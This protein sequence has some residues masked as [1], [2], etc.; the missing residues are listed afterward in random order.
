MGI[1]A[2]KMLQDEIVYLIQNDPDIGEILI[3]ENGEHI[4][5]V[6]KLNEMDISYKLIPSVDIL[7]NRIRKGPE[8][9]NELP[10]PACNEL[11]DQNSADADPETISLVVW[12]LDLGLHEVPKKLKL[13][14]YHDL[15]IMMPKVDGVFLFYGL[16][17]NVLLTVEDD[18][19]DENCPVLILR[20]SDGI[21]IDDC[22]G[23]AIG[24][25]QKYAQLLKSFKGVGTF[26]LTPMYAQYAATDFFGYGQAV[27]GFSNEKMYEMNK[28]MF[29]ASGYKQTALLD[30]GLSYTKNVEENAQK[31]ADKYNF[32]II[33]LD[34]GN[35]KIFED[36]YRKM[37]QKIQ[38]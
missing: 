19:R 13:Q 10:L 35:Q 15:P 12:Q 3:V 29:E 34:G 32:K 2:C 24:G 8:D 22:I 1:L 37:K 23:G 30:T 31:F 20:D 14:V 7:P 25:R 9:L 26:I 36:C 6:Q 5:F 11:N 38:V 33:Q 18:F 17:G 16:C 4:D 28:F 21:I 27:S